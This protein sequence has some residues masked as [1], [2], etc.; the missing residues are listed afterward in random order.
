MQQTVGQPSANTTDCDHAK[1][2]LDLFAQHYSKLCSTL[3]T[4]SISL[5][6]T[7]ASRDI[8]IICRYMPHRTATIPLS[9]PPVASTCLFLCQAH[10][11][12]CNDTYVLDCAAER[13]MTMHKVWSLADGMCSRVRS[14]VTKSDISSA[15]NQGSRE[16]LERSYREYMQSELRRHRN[17]VHLTLYGLLFCIA[18]THAVIPCIIPCIVLSQSWHDLAYV[19]FAKLSATLF[20]GQLIRQWVCSGYLAL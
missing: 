20:H 19:A 12:L 10:T 5:H 18:F 7:N 14:Q 16:F 3:W 15:L 13:R 17:Q 9:F 6:M 1:V 4:R 8:R 2:Q 11:P